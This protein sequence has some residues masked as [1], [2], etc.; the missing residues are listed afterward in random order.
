MAKV[1]ISP[2]SNSTNEYIE[3]VKN[4]IEHNNS[5]V[6]PLSITSIFSKKLPEFFNRRNTL[7]FHW[8]EIGFS[9]KQAIKYPSVSAGQWSG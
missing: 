9:K 1:F 5:V 4:I 2:F 6:E 3:F 7:V 8:V